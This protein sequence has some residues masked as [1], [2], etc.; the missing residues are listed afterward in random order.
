MKFKPYKQICDT[1]HNNANP[2]TLFKLK[3]SKL[4]LQPDEYTEQLNFQFYVQ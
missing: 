4:S 2:S 3:G 1:E